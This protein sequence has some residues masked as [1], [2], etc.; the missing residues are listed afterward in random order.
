M[1]SPPTSRDSDGAGSGSTRVSSVW[2]V[3]LT[4]RT[5]PYDGRIC[6]AL[7][8]AGIDLTLWA[9]GSSRPEL[10]DNINVPIRRGITDLATRI[11]VTERTG[12]L[13]KGLK[14][15]EY[16][17][18]LIALVLSAVR[19][20]P[21]IIHF[22]WLP[23][24]DHV[25]F[26]I[27]V[28]RWLQRQGIPVVYTAHDVVPLDNPTVTEAYRTLYQSVDGIICH[29]ET[30]QAHLTADFGVPQSRIQRIPH[31][32]L[33]NRDALPERAH[34]RQQLGWDESTPV[35]L[36][37]GVLR[38]YK[39][40]EFLLRSW[41][42]VREKCPEARLVIAGHANPSYAST[43]RA[44]VRKHNLG[45]S[46]D[47]RFRFL[48]DDEL[49]ALISASD[50]LVYPYR[51]ITQSGALFAGMNAGKAVVATAVGGLAEV[52]D[53][54]ANGRLVPYD[55]APALADTLGHVLTHP[56]EISKLGTA[57]RRTMD[58]AYSWSR[59]ADQTIDWYQQVA[60]DQRLD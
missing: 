23:F 21:D 44:L 33:M 56:D 52:I 5:P 54:G 20:R 12:P 32:P 29:T 57:A 6:E 15:I 22:Q 1:P 35:A 34:A 14:A 41:R 11:P 25:P 16:L 2:V 27:W 50:V 17:I 39:G 55:D 42:M 10:L 40:A 13:V 43:L 28:V 58:T 31:G 47:L 59:I 46:V 60:G 24:L 19:E 45:T 53:D 3:D 18:N 8:E 36:L 30:A 4:S 38:P 7:K 26:E 51:N 9:A 48:P 49:H 37:F